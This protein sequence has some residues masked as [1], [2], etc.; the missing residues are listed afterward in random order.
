MA[1]VIRLIFREGM[2]KQ[3]ASALAR[4]NYSRRG[5]ARERGLTLWREKADLVIAAAYRVLPAENQPD[6]GS[7]GLVGTGK[8]R[9]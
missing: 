3:R 7:K 4:A 6:D 5:L 1:T 8:F 9:G 2:P